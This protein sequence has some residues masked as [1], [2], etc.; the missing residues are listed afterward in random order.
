MD[1]FVRASPDGIDD[2]CSLRLALFGRAM[3]ADLDLPGFRTVDEG[4]FEFIVDDIGLGEYLCGILG[5]EG[6]VFAAVV[7]YGCICPVVE[8]ES[9]G[10]AV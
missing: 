5:A 6:D 10:E 9:Q 7:E 3:R 1:G 8:G 2:S 4:S